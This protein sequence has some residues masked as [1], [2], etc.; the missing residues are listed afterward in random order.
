MIETSPFKMPLRTFRANRRCA[1][2]ALVAVVI[3]WSLVLIGFPA[4]AP[5][6]AQ[7]SGRIYIDIEKTALRK[8]VIQVGL[9][10]V[11]SG[12]ME[13]VTAADLVEDVVASDLEYSGFF[14]VGVGEHAAAPD[15]GGFEFTIAGSVEG[16]LRDARQ[17]G[18][19]V[20]TTVT[21]QLLSYPERQALLTKRYRPRPEQ[22]RIT[23][24]H[25]ANQVIEMLTGSK[26]ICLTRICFSRGSGDR[27]DLW[28][29][30]YDGENPLRVTANR[31]LNLCPSWSPDGTEIAFT[32]YETGRQG[33][34]S[35]D[36]ATGRVRLIIRQPGLNLGADWH[37]SGRELLVSL[38]HTG[39]PEIYRIDPAGKILKRL[40]VSPAIEVS[41]A[42]NP[43]GNRVVF[44]SDRTG[45]PQ[46]YIMDV[47]GAGRERLTYEGRY[48][49]SAVWS[50]SG[51][52]LVYA[53]REGVYTQ[54]VMIATTGEDRQILTS[55]A[56]RNAEDPSWAP[57]GRHV[58]FASDRTG[59]FKLYVLDVVDGDWRQ[60]TFGDEPDITPDWSP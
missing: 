28:V 39:D 25:F 45:S 3:C 2:T 50:P 32:S 6:R 36:T 60:L 16:P 58:V 33:L 41:A 49:D 27:R 15:T 8:I 37:P 17:T 59:T 29:V 14:R 54:L 44:T 48:N 34:Y 56:W 35:L 26:G 13:A 42:W 47:D 21:L 7:T 5:V 30:D 18:E 10:D 31:T 4:A 53:L 24:H 46:L 38:S 1:A 55:G 20:P 52:K 9:L 11:L 19:E 12:G 40:T 51:D 57:D 22:L 43:A 23:A